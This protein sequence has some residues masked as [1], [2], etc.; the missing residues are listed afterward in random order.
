MARKYEAGEQIKL[1][2]DIPLSGFVY[3]TTWNRPCHVGWFMSMPAR[4]VQDYLT[5]GWVKT[6]KLKEEV[7][8]GT[9]S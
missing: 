9:A 2:T 1:F 7:N 5:R 3:I 6:A 8:N 4:L